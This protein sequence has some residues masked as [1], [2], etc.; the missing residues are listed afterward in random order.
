MRAFK[1]KKK[2]EKRIQD[3]VAASGLHNRFSDMGDSANQW[4][5]AEDMGASEQVVLEKPEQV[6]VRGGKGGGGRHT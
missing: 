3:W 6:V 1:H 5:S 2:Q 4:G